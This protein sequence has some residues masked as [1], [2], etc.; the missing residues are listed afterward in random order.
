MEEST[1]KNERWPLIRQAIVFQFKLGLDA[2][3]DILMSPVSIILVVIDTAMANQHQQSYFLG[4]M[5]IGKQSD[6]WINLFGDSLSKDETSSNE[7]IVNNNVDY[8]FSRIEAVIKEQQV[9]G[10]ISQS[11]REKLQQYFRKVS[12]SL[13]KTEGKDS[14]KNQPDYLHK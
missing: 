1:S 8:W 11:S 13:D 3:R 10:K 9:N 2:L 4:L 14:N 12:Q 6:H 7:E 5:R